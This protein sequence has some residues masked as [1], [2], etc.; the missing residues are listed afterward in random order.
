M[1]ADIKASQ[2]ES[3]RRN[4]MEPVA[5]IKG[6]IRRKG[7]FHTKMAGARLVMNEH[8]N[9][10]NTS[11]PG[12]LWWEYVKLLERKPISVGWQ[13]KKP[14]PWKKSHEFLR[15]SMAAHVVD[16]FRIHCGKGDSESWARSCTEEDFHIVTDKVFE[17]LFSTQ[18]YDEAVK[19]DDRDTVYE[20]TILYNRDCLIYLTFTVAIKQGDIG[21]VCNVLRFWQ[22]MMR[23][24][25]TMPRYADAIFE[26]LGR[27]EVYDP[28][29]K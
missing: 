2:M 19:K 5:G 3:A 8:W 20:N 15:I 11:G 13:S 17:A 9:T 1:A 25:K 26:T 6:T 10:P 7:L 16:A 14:A 28:K 4:S 29:P 27:L 12:S 24:P 22:V 23:A 21:T 18:A